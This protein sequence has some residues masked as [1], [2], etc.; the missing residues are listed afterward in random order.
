MVYTARGNHLAVYRAA[1]A[2]TI[3]KFN[4][5][6]RRASARCADSER[7]LSGSRVTRTESSATLLE[8][9]S[10]GNS[11]PIT[12]FLPPFPAAQVRSIP[13][14][15]LGNMTRLRALRALWSTA[16]LKKPAPGEHTYF[17]AVYAVAA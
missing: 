13:R 1:G 9:N 11:R 6:A 16:K 3:R 15:D 10:T 2:L 4:A 17:T 5:I 8:E 12:S 7:R 14:D